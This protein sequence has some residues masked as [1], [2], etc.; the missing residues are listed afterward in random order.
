MAGQVGVSGHYTIGD[1]AV[2]TAQA[3]IISDVPAGQTYGGFPGQPHRQS[4]RGYAAL[5]K[6]P[7]LLRRLERLLDREEPK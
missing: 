2:L 6:L 1:R 4:M 5:L 3:G 7:D